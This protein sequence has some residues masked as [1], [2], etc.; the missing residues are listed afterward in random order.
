MTLMHTMAATRSHVSSSMVALAAASVLLV[1]AAGT[2]VL[3]RGGENG[4]PLDACAAGFDA[5]T[6]G[7]GCAI[8][9]VEPWNPAG[10]LPAALFPAAVK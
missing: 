3:S 7:C 5:G 6:P 4:T 8:A 10:A 9:P 1:G 2:F